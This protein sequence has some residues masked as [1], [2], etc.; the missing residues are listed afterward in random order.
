MNYLA[1]LY[2]SGEDEKIMVGNFIGDYIKGNK[3]LKFPAEIQKGI[4]IHRNIDTFTDNHP[5]FKEAK[6]FLQAEFG[7]YSAVI[8]D[9]FYDHLLAVNWS[10]YS[11]VSLQ[12]FTRKVH[13]VLLSHFYYLPERVQRFLPSLIQNRRLESY[14]GREGIQ[15]SMEIMSRYTSLP[16]NAEKAMQILHENIDFFTG[17]FAFFMQELTH[18]V[19]TDFCIAIKKPGD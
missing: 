6:R 16:S 14:A 9:L 3:F 17:N 19:E 4:L 12:E 10:L 13:T 7:L 1:H 8:I 18:Y 15:K 5:K 11:E 2:L